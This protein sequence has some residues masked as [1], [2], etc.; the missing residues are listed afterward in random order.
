MVWASPVSEGSEGFKGSLQKKNLKGEIFSSLS[1]IWT[2]DLLVAK[3]VW[4][5][6]DH[7][8]PLWYLKSLL[9]SIVFLNSNMNYQQQSEITLETGLN[10]SRFLFGQSKLSHK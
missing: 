4:S 8:T 1:G 9:S 6:L 2:T 7:A 3:P 10:L 5:P